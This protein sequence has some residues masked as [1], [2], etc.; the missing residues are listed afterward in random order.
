MASL[1][2]ILI[3]LKK[4][5][6]STEIR[7]VRFKKLILGPGLAVWL[8]LNLVVHG[9]LVS[10]H[11]Q[12]PLSG[13]PAP[14]KWSALHILAATCPCSRRVLT[15]LEN[16]GVLPE[17]SEEIALVDGSP[18]RVGLLQALGFEVSSLSPNELDDF[19]G[20]VLLPQ[21]IVR[22]PEGNTLYAGAYS[23]GPQ[24]PPQGDVILVQLRG[25]K[26]VARLAN[27]GCDISRGLIIRSGKTRGAGI[28]F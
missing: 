22:D 26:P 17:W 4:F 14:G 21:L 20:Q 10:S 11:S 24:L 3:W 15:H 23:A 9:L 6:V 19:C 7:Q 25:G 27:P 28:A 18:E 8:F 12:L 1:D 16:R 2:H 13:R 5:L